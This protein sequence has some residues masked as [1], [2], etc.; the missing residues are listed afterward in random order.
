M[1]S[2]QHDTIEGSGDTR[3]PLGAFDA[4]QVDEDN[5]ELLFEER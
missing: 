1:I 2:D 5:I 4:G 3:D